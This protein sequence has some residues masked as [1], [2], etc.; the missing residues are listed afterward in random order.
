MYYCVTS[1]LQQQPG[2]I[3]KIGAINE[4]IKN[5]YRVLHL[6]TAYAYLYN[7]IARQDVG[8]NAVREMADITRMHGSAIRSVRSHSCSIWNMANLTPL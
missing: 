1:F 5:I 2:K 3:V 8:S 7:K 4:D 6:N